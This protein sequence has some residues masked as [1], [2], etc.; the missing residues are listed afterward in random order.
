MTR[1]KYWLS[2]LAISVVLIAGSLAVSPIAI[3]DDDDDDDDNDDNGGVPGVR[4]EWLECRPTS[5]GQPGDPICDLQTG[6]ALNNLVSAPPAGTLVV[7]EPDTNEHASTWESAPLTAPLTLL[8]GPVTLDL[9]H[10]NRSENADDQ[11]ICWSKHAILPNGNEIVIVQ[12]HC[13]EN[14]LTAAGFICPNGGVQGGLVA[15]FTPDI[16]AACLAAAGVASETVPS[17]ILAPTVLPVGTV[18]ELNISCPGASFLHIF[19]NNGVDV[20]G[21]GI[22]EFTKLSEPAI[23]PEVDDDEDD[24]DDDDNDDD[25]NDDD[26]NDD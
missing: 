11:D 3:A 26:D 17:L 7:L 15:P 21:D 23:I 16:S 25:D 4:M 2:I 19:F 20:D 9:V 12:Q 13:F 14:P 5:N 10:V 24:D 1:T 8:P 6:I 18:I 22:K